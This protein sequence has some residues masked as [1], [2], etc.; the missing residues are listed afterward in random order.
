M[1]KRGQVSVFV[2][3][4]V[5]VLLTFVFLFFLRDEVIEKIRS[6]TDTEAYLSS[7]LDRIKIE[8]IDK[9]IQEETI[10]AIRVFGE[11][12]GTFTP[13]H[14]APLYAKNVNFLCKNIKGKDTCLN[15]GFIHSDVEKYLQDYLN[16]A[17]FNCIN[18]NAFEN[19]DYE[20][21]TGQ[22]NLDLNVRFKEILVKV[23]YPITLTK[24]EKSAKYDNYEKIFAVPLGAF[25]EIVNKIL[26]SEAKTGYFDPALFYSQYIVRWEYSYPHKVYI[27]EP[28]DNSYKFQF[29]VESEV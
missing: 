8:V 2:I 24:G 16:E 9:C 21:K 3:I 14:S 26:D 4:G 22:F 19:K 20:I 10:A 6:N 13:V 23:N 17:V 25:I 11:Q 1:L 15:Q 18:L 5:V 28:V 29:A 27:I 7:Q 12:G